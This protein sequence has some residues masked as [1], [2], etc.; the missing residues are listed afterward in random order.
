M[1]NVQGDQAKMSGVSS[2]LTEHQ[3]ILGYLVSYDAVE[4]LDKRV[5]I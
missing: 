1:R 4:D 5:R 2:F 3:H